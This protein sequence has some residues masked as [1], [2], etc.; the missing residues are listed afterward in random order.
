VNG[1]FNKEKTIEHTEEINIY[2]QEHGERTDIN[3]IG[4]QK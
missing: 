4:G 1:F 3:V 2:Y